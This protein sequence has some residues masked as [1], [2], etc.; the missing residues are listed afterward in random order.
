M[1]SWMI[2]LNGAYQQHRLT[3]ISAWISNYIHRNVWDEITSP[4]PN[5][6]EVWE[7]INNCIPHLTGHVI[8]YPWLFMLHFRVVQ[9]PSSHFFAPPYDFQYHLIV[10]WFHRIIWDFFCTFGHLLLAKCCFSHGK[11]G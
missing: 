9:H 2:Y 11:S 7:W 1:V 4:F 5:F 8:T 6:I 3:L 10:S